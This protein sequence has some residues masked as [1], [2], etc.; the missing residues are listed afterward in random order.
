MLVS[1]CSHSE[2]VK[3]EERMTPTLTREE[4]FIEQAHERVQES[5]ALDDDNLLAYGEAICNALEAGITVDELGTFIG[6]EVQDAEVAGILGSLGAIAATNLCPE[7]LD[8]EG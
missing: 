6:Y 5:R 1:G 2:P 8:K 3:G 7:A 4:L